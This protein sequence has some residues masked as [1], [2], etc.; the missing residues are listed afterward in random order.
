MD[1]PALQRALAD[2]RIDAW[3]LYDFH[4]QLRPRERVGLRRPGE[5]A[6]PREAEATNGRATRTRSRLASSR[7]RA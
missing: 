3:L 2:Q 1:V 7:V 4:G 6:Q 5:A